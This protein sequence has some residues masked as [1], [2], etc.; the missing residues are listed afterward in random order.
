MREST[1]YRDLHEIW[2]SSRGKKG[3]RNDTPRIGAARSMISDKALWARK[4]N[5]KDS[6]LDMVVRGE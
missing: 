2:A 3:K 4:S 5:R 6:E 1:H